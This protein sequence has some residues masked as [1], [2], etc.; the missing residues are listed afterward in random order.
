MDMFSDLSRPVAILAQA[1][2]ASVLSKQRSLPRNRSSVSM[3]ASSDPLHAS[4]NPPH[5]PVKMVRSRVVPR[6]L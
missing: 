4:G 6:E 3:Y 1:V 5:A 2:R